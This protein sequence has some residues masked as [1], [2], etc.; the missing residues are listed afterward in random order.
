MEHQGEDKKASRSSAKTSGLQEKG[1][2]VF[3]DEFNIAHPH[4][5]S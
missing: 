5:L 2:Q 1:R 3:I 4:L